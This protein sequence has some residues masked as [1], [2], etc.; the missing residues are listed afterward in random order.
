MHK[1]LIKLSELPFKVL[2]PGH[3]NIIMHEKLPDILK[4]D[5]NRMIDQAQ[6][7]T[8][9]LNHIFYPRRQQCQMPKFKCQ[10][11]S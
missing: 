8:E 1:S 4:R 5:T 10:M 11:K 9:L 7:T 3:G 6:R 2:L